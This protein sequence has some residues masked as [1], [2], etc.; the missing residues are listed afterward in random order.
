MVFK[1]EVNINKFSAIS[2]YHLVYQKELLLIEVRKLSV[3]NLTVSVDARV[4]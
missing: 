1:H 2:K 4:Q 3:S